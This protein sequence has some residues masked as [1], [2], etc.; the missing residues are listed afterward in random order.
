MAGKASA[1]HNDAETTPARPLLGMP[2]G[3]NV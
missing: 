2:D 3:L 1:S